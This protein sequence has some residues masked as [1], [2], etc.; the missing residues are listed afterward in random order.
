MTRS[1]DL[2]ALSG[3]FN[4][5]I[6]APYVMIR[7][8]TPFLLLKVNS[9][10]GVPSRVLPKSSSA[11]SARAT[12][13][14]IRDN[15]IAALHAR[16]IF[17]GGSVSLDGQIGRDVDA[18]RRRVEGGLGAVGDLGELGVELLDL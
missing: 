6:V 7:A 3:M 15:T 9:R 2:P 11:T 16:R 13:V 10:T 17:I 8:T 4:E 1:S 5:T 18:F 14:R 12:Q